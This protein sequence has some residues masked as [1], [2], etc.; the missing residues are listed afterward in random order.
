MFIFPHTHT[1]QGWELL[2]TLEKLEKYFVDGAPPGYGHHPK[3]CYD[4]ASVWES[5]YQTRHY[6]TSPMP[7]KI[8]NNS[9]NNS[10]SASIIFIYLLM[11]N[12]FDY[13]FCEIWAT[14]PG[15]GCSSCNSSATQSRNACWV[16]FCFNNLPLSHGLQDL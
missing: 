15:K 10:T 2:P 14:L 13:P 7:S 9:A 12:T 16:F 4:G 1:S 5:R 3:L 6:C 8:Q 11:F